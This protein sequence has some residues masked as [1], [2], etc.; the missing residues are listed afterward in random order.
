MAAFKSTLRIAT[1][2][3]SV[4]IPR[5]DATLSFYL[6]FGVITTTGSFT[7]DI[8]GD[9]LFEATDADVGIYGGA[10][11]LVELDVSKYADHKVHLLR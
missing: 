2:T 11:R 4:T 7:V 3:Q 8:D 10:Y 6:W 1:V 5:G 9:V